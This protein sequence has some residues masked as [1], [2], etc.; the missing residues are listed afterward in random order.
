MVDEWSFIGVRDSPSFYRF[1]LSQHGMVHHHGD[2]MDH[3]DDRVVRSM[4]GSDSESMCDCNLWVRSCGADSKSVLSRVFT[5]GVVSGVGDSFSIYRSGLAYSFY[6][7]G[8]YKASNRSL[9]LVGYMELDHSLMDRMCECMCSSIASSAYNQTSCSKAENSFW[10]IYC[11]RGDNGVDGRRNDVGRLFRM[12][13]L[14]LVKLS[15]SVVLV[16]VFVHI[17]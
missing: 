17:L 6:G 9:Y 12:V 13:S 11:T 14:I 16:W 7:M 1:L 8:R 4:D 10:S 2:S 5:N 15:S 3:G